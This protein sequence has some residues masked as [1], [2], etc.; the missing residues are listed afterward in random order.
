MTTPDELIESLQLLP[1]PEGG[2][3]R[4]TYRSEMSF[5]GD[6]PFPNGRNI[7]TAIYFM[8]TADG[9]SA[10]HRIKS[11]E[12]WH[13]YD[14]D[15]FEIIEITPGGNLISTCIGKGLYQYTVPKG[16]WFGS[17]VL[18]GGKWSLVGCTVS[19]GFDFRDFE[20]ASKSG[21]SSQF[22]SHSQVINEM[23]RIP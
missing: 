3:Y 15:P 9:F 2:W 6:G 18:H 14:G 5:D 7:A 23:T 10:L 22:P 20:L 13:F 11:D 17:R 4:E 19:P 16:N 21:L 12:T 1:H 8:I